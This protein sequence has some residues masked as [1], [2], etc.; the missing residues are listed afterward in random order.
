ML[1]LPLTKT[2]TH[3]TRASYDRR[4]T[5]ADHRIQ[6]P[7]IPCYCLE[8][9]P[10]TTIRHGYAPVPFSSQSNAANGIRH[11]ESS[12]RV[13]FPADD[14]TSRL[15]RSGN[16]SARKRRRSIPARSAALTVEARKPL[17]DYENTEKRR[18][19]QIQTKIRRIVDLWSTTGVH[20][21]L[22]AID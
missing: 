3:T 15:L 1:Y 17:T 22:L 21:D 19:E 13:N 7:R 2:Q 20:T 8:Y 11:S 18:I 12:L 5:K 16:S 14:G 4:N 9:W 6:H 10:G